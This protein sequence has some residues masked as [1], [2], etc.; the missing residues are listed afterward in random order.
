[1]FHRHTPYVCPTYVYV[2]IMFHKL[3]PFVCATSMYLMY[4]PFKFMHNM[5]V[6]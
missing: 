1:M 4:V 2:P 3:A 6:P 5:F